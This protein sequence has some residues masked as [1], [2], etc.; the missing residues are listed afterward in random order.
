MKNT[1]KTQRKSLV[2]SGSFFNYL[3]ANN[4][5]VPVVGKGATIML[6]SDRNVAEVVEVSEDGKK[7]VI[8]HLDA[9]NIGKQYG[10]QDWEFTASGRTQT[11]VWRNN[12]WR[13]EDV[14]ISFTKNILE[15]FEASN[16]NS[17]IN[18]L[19]NK[20]PGI[21]ERIFENEAYPQNIIEGITEAKKVYSKI[22]ILFGAKNY[23]YDYSF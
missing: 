15:E 1:L 4:S 2:T 19:E 6:W 13:T 18:F 10:E 8:E 7:V 22:N 12:A 21:T 9:K 23:Y 5:S 17:V 16:Y 11:I 20:C 3:M 14:K